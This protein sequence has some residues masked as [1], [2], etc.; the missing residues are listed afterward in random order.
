MHKGKTQSGTFR[1]GCCADSDPTA[2]VWNGNQTLPCSPQG[3]KVLGTSWGHPE[4]VS[5]ELRQVS[6]CHSIFFERIPSVSYLQ[7]TSH[8][9][10][11]CARTQANHLL[12]AL[13]PHATEEYVAEHDGS[14][15]RCL[16]R[17]LESDIFRPPHQSSPPSRGQ[18][19]NRVFNEM[20]AIL[21][22]HAP[23]QRCHRGHRQPS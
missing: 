13:L 16:D 19:F 3:V 21:H 4:F 6:E 1:D 23:I 22:R 7:A 18:L 14:M 20:I 15:R 11:Y 12:R 17:L 10:L 2:I 8:L 5:A 9:L